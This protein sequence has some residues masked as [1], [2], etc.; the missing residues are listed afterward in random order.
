MSFRSAGS[1]ISSSLRYMGTERHINA[2]DMELQ[3]SE[4]ALCEYSNT[5]ALCLPQTRLKYS[6]L[7]SSISRHGQR[8]GFVGPG[9]CTDTSVYS[10]LTI[11][12]ERHNPCVQNWQLCD[13]YRVVGPEDGA[14]RAN[15]N[16]L[17]SRPSQGDGSPRAQ[18]A[19]FPPSPPAGRSAI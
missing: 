10:Y 15:L 18:L 17:V 4:R 13:C 8:E 9:I 3:D 19:G 5:F 6:Y 16:S 14:R 2:G 7:F 11:P 12:L 1:L